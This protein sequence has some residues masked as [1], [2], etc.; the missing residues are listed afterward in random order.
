MRKCGKVSQTRYESRLVG[1]NGL[2]PVYRKE[3]E[4][5][6]STHP[7]T[8]T[9]QRNEKKGASRTRAGRAPI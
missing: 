2:K 1:E 3:K 9:W 7:T 8:S 4:K 6:P 5:T